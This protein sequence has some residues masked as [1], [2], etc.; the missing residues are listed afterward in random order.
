MHKKP[1][2]MLEQT[3]S[4][5]K[6]EEQPPDGWREEGHKQ[7]D[8]EERE[9]RRMMSAGRRAAVFKPLPE[10]SP[11]L[12]ERGHSNDTSMAGNLPSPVLHPLRCRTT[13]LWCHLD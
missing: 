7:E 3:S 8:R 12:R 10:T 4:V 13:H 2:E 1:A 11:L 6:D 9:E 5:K